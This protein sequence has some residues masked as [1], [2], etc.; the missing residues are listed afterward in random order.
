MLQAVD[1]YLTTLTKGA[2]PPDLLKAA[3]MLISAFPA[4][5][6]YRL[7]PSRTSTLKHLFSIA[8]SGTLF[9]TLFN[10]GGF[11]QLLGGSLVVYAVTKGFRGRKWGPVVVFLGAMGQ[12]SIK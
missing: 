7:I 11:I 6:L 4:A 3:V 5:A 10:L 1:T 9:C 12:L 2:I 8:M